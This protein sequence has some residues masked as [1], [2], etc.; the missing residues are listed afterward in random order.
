MCYDHGGGGNSCTVRGFGFEIVECT[1]PQTPSHGRPSS[2]HTSIRGLKSQR[3]R[4][5]FADRNSR[6]HCSQIFRKFFIIVQI[7]NFSDSVFYILCIK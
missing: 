2:L 5:A 3:M 4:I 7:Y 6:N 1:A